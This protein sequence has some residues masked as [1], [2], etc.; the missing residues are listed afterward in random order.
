M[1]ERLY[2]KVTGLKVTGVIPRPQWLN[3]RGKPVSD[4]E[5]VERGVYPIY[6]NRPVF[7]EQQVGVTLPVH[8]VDE[9]HFS[10][11]RVKADRVIKTY[12]VTEVPLYGLQNHLYSELAI[13]RYRYE[14]GGMVF[15]TVDGD[16]LQIHTAR[17]AQAAVMR[18]YVAAQAGLRRETAPFKTRT[19][20]VPLSNADALRLGSALNTFIQ[21]CFDREDAVAT[22][23]HQAETVTELQRIKDEELTSG[24]PE[25][26]L[27]VQAQ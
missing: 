22:M 1:A 9:K 27:L 24:W 7:A 26:S 18:V 10:E 2:A 17:E 25:A 14:V 20:F 4:A 21:M 3:A 5:L 8:Q 12:D 6:E 23:I 13:V 11:W 16:T 19:G 15:V